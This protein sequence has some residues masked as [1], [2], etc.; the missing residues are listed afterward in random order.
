MLKNIR[1]LA[2]TSVKKSRFVVFGQG[3]TGSTLLASLLSSHS[4]IQCDGEILAERVRHSLG[5]IESHEAASEK[6]VYGFKVKIYQLS[7]TQKLVPAEFL[8]NLVNVGTKIIFLSRRNLL[9]HAL[10]NYVARANR[11]HFRIGERVDVKPV[12][13]EPEELLEVMNRRAEH[14]RK[15]EAAVLN[16]DVHR[17]VY[18]D[19]LIDPVVQQRSLN[20]CF[21][22]LGVPLQPVFTDLIRGVTG[23]L[24]SY[25]S[26]YS[27]VAAALKNTQYEHFL[28]DPAYR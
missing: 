23:P 27:E 4:E 24:S 19:D 20:D 22:F 2:D 9:R 17:M 5:Y 11:Y 18:E 16:L 8:R 3:R 28:S 10:S 6:P 12:H 25:F 1:P 7:E 13:F 15:E 21:T 26:N 14:R